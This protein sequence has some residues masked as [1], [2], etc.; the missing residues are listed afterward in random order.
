MK[1][2][3]GAVKNPLKKRESLHPSDGAKKAGGL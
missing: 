3:L 2:M 1:T